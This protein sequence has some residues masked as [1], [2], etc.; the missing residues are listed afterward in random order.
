[1]VILSA[2][3]VWLAGTALPPGPVAASEGVTIQLALDGTRLEG[4]P[5]AWN[6]FQVLLLARNGFLFSFPPQKAEDFRQVSTRF[7]PWSQS[8]MRGQ[9]QREFGRGFDV[10]GTGNYLVVHPAGQKDRWAQRF[11]NLYRSFVHYFSVRGMRPA[12]PDFPLVAIVLHSQREFL[13]Y[14][15]QS[16]GSVSPG[17][18][19]YYS[20]Q[21]NRIM[22]YDVTHGQSTDENWFI[23]AETII[24]EATHQMA[25]NTQIHSRT[26]SPPRWVA[27]GLAM[28]F[29]APGV[30]DPRHHRDRNDR[31]NRGRLQAFRQY[32]PHRPG[33]S[34]PQFVSQSAAE[35]SST[36]NASYAEAW[37]FTFFLS[38]Q[39]P[40]KLMKYL[41]KTSGREP[42]KQYGQAERLQEFTDVFGRDFKMLEARFLRFIR[43]LQAK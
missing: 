22:L 29:E 26:A 43:Q 24:H 11:E 10:S 14:S 38:E 18:L 19:G 39:E 28:L 1:M 31:M 33:G 27:E 32:L 4:T 6:Q 30:W 13:E 42:L 15:R 40:A 9:L 20:P 5:V 36:P 2:G 23:N 8:E 17:V 25:F 37:A 12:T 7:Q 21:T 34:L 41:A 35:F 3:L 16:G